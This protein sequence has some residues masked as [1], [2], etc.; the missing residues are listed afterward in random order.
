MAEITIVNQSNK[1]VGKRELNPAVFGLDADAAFVHRV[2]AALASAQRGGTS[3]VKDRSEVS[4]GGKKPWKQKGTG[5]A[6]AG[7]SR[8]AQWRH[9]GTAHG[10]S[11][12][13][14]FA[15]RINKKERRRALCLALSDCLREGKLTVVDKLEL[16][17]IK[18][19]AFVDTLGALGADSGLIVL[20]ES[21]NAVELSGR[22]VPNTR[23]VLD[24]QVNL[25][26]LLK[27]KRVVLTS[28][29]ID[30]LEERLA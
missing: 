25:H 12:D 1:E 19:K 14:S 11:A 10:P 20:G 8:Q 27:S 3:K 21:N 7:S 17:E 28:A 13:T 4:G 18:T 9:G 26:D 22:N 29:A 24:G 30:N 6:R 5:R 15:T 2:Y 16:A 23:I